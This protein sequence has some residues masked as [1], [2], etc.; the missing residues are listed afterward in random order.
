MNVNNLPAR[1][2]LIPRDKMRDDT[3]DGEL[4]R[5]VGTPYGMLRTFLQSPSDLPCNPPPWGTLVAV[6]LQTG[7]IGW[8]VP[9]GSMQNF[10]GA[11]GP[12]PNGSISLGGPIVTAAGL[13]FISG[14]TDPHLRAFDIETGKELWSAEL[15]A[16]GNA[17]PM[18]YEMNGKQYVVIAAGGH[19]RIPEEKQ[20]D[21]IVA[22]AL[23]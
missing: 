11:H 2:R 23:P 15:P 14:T 18:T 20:G 7:T 13:V 22:F 3:E 6:D 9:L 16:S 8:R 5:Q 4:G 19:Q 12:I 21:A 1:V 10:G 17:A